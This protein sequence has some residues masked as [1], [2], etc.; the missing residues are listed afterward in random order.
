MTALAESEAAHEST[1]TALA[2]EQAKAEALAVEAA[3]VQGKLAKLNDDLIQQGKED[4]IAYAHTNTF[5]I[6]E[7]KMGKFYR[8]TMYASDNKIGF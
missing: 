6:M 7:E 3:E 5:F 4:R 8:D 2:N 1:K